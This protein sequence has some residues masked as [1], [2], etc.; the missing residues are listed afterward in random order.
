MQ[1][2]QYFKDLCTEMISKLVIVLLEDPRDLQSL[3]LETPSRNGI[4]VL[5]AHG[6]RSLHLETLAE[7]LE[8]KLNPTRSN[9]ID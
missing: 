3:N 8:G 9:P 2:L 7:V 5:C 4:P 1:N 6:G